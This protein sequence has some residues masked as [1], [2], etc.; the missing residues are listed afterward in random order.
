MK[1]PWNNRLIYTFFLSY[2]AI[3]VLL[4]LGFF[5]Y[6]RNLLR[7]FYAS[8]LGKV[9]EQKTRVLARQLPWSDEPGS[10]DAI[11]RTLADELGVRITVIAQNGTVI[12]DSDEPA[13]QL[14]NH[15]SRP[16]VIEALSRGAG[17]AVRYSTSTKQDLLYHAYRQNDGP[18]QRVLRVAVSF[19]EVQNVTRS[20]GRTLLFGLLLCSLLGLAVAYLF[21]RRLSNR[22]NRLAEFS[23]AVAEG[24]FAQPL[25]PRSGDDELNVLEQNLRDM[26]LKI[27][28]NINALKIRERKSRL[29]SQMHG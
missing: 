13:G 9:M 6:S 27:R 10:L 23:K 22:V 8:S 21:S 15:G 11:C 25:L 18:R 2:L 29:D 7:D 20:L 5:L 1:R 4:S 17:S 16:E 28:D 3:I 19:S 26:S 24:Q 14:E 12:G